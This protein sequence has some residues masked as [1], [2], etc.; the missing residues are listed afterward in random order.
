LKDFGYFGDSALKEKEL[1]WDEII[2]KGHSKEFVKKPILF[3]D[4]FPL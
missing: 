3:I 1:F 4:N 2:V